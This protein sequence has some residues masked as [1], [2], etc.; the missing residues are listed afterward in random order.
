MREPDLVRC[1]E[2]PA[3]L[4]FDLALREEWDSAGVAGEDASV[5]ER[6]NRS[7]R[8]A[9]AAACEWLA[10]D[11]EEFTERVRAL[12]RRLDVDDSVGSMRVQPRERRRETDHRASVPRDTA[13]RGR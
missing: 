10:P 11:V 9:H 1:E 8:R 2:R 7:V 5:E 6:G 13:G 12:G 4:E 3:D